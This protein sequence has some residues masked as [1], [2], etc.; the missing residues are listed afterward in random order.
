VSGRQ[1]QVQVYDYAR[2]GWVDVAQEGGPHQLGMV[3]VTGAGVRVTHVVREHG[4]GGPQLDVTVDPQEGEAVSLAT[5]ETYGSTLQ[6]RLS[7]Q[8]RPED[9][10]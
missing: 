4:K 7:I 6:A 2:H 8:G 9:P 1:L 3:R 5:L 10:R